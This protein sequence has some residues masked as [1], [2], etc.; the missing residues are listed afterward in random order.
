MTLSMVLFHLICHRLKW[1]FLDIFSGNFCAQYQIMCANL[2]LECF[3]IYLFFFKSN[4][5][6]LMAIGIKCLHSWFKNVLCLFDI[7][8]AF[9]LRYD[10][11]IMLLYCCFG[12][13]FSDWSTVQHDNG[14]TYTQS[15]V[16]NTCLDC[17][18]NSDQVLIQFII[19][20]LYSLVFTACSFY[21]CSSILSVVSAFTIFMVG[22]YYGF[23]LLYY[24]LVK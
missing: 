16:L 5:N 11:L 17:L 3:A 20:C 10:I 1:A 12:F 9:H 7:Q 18:C 6:N 19:S 21:L 15:H 24:L 23:C 4:A 13:F 22:L 2:R 14:S 8:T